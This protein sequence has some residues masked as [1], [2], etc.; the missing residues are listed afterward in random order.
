MF[1]ILENIPGIHATIVGVLATFFSAYFMFVCQKVIEAK[2]NLEKVLK[3]A[4]RIST[5]DSSVSNGYSPLI[6]ENGN[7]DWDEKCK[8]LIRKAKTELSEN[9]IDRQKVTQIV[10]ELTPFFSLF[11]TNYPM[12]GVSRVTTSQSVLK[13]INNTFDYDRYSEIHRRISYLMWVWNTS[14]HHLIRLFEIYDQI[15]AQENKNNMQIEI[16]RVNRDFEENPGANQQVRQRIFQQIRDNFNILAHAERLPLLFDF[17]QRVKEYDAQVIPTLE[18]TTKDFKYYKD[19]LNVME[20]TKTVLY[21]SMFIM[22][23]GIIL[24][25]ILVKIIGNSNEPYYNCLIN[26]VEYIILIL[27][28][29]PYFIMGFFFL[30]KIENSVFKQL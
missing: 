16:D 23:V 29:A 26:S 30:K 5:L 25:L 4:K 7:L 2:N 9:E 15:K 19:E 24:P 14:Q 11:F 10:D 3:D 27:S 8:N 21:T 12:N 6:D 1:P 18:E 13:K 17:F 22:V 28:F 20:N